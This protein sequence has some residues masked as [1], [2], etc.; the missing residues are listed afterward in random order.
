MLYIT[1]LAR[2]R[3][4]QADQE[5]TVTLSCIWSSKPVYDILSQTKPNKRPMR[6]L[7]G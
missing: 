6:R 2:G 7:G 3:Q 5:F 4:R 1:I